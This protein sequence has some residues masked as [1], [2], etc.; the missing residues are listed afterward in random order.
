M[1]SAP[2]P[3]PART[4]YSAALHLF[5][6]LCG[7]LD[8]LCGLCAEFRSF[9][10]RPSLPSRADSPRRRRRGLTLIL[11]GIEGPST[12]NQAMGMGVLRSGYR[13]AV[14]RF[15]WNGGIPFIRSAVNL[16]S[17]R[18]HER[19]SDLLAAEIEAHARGY[20]DSPINLVAQ[21]GGCWI[22]V[23]ALEKLPR[24][25]QVDTAVLLAASISPDRDLSAAAQRCRRGLVSVG[26]PGDFF[27]LGLGTLFCGT[28]DRVHGPS[29]GWV[30]W[31]NHP[32]GFAE[33][34]WRPEWI[35]HGYLGNHTSSAAPR[36]IQHVIA[37]Q[38]RDGRRLHP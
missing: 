35:R 14:V 23:R 9:I 13:G 1:S 16:M 11:G 4:R 20:P 15:N 18:H 7:L 31:R 12:Y 8:P 24:G 26:G 22:V 27:F 37:P 28:S 5:A 29:A 17:G 30:S 38:L 36:F 19:Q 3:L 34:R 21:S 10:Q 33:L 32:R 2:L 25:I 6:V